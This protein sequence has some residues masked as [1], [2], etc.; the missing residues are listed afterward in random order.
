M[1]ANGKRSA[2]IKIAKVK[3]TKALGKIV[4]GRAEAGFNLEA[5]PA[6]AS[7]GRK[8]SGTK[9]SAATEGS[10]NRAYWGGM[11]GYGRDSMDVNVN[12]SITNAFREKASLSGSGFS[13]KGLFDY[14]VFP[15]AWFRFTTG[16]E[17]FKVSGPAKC[18]SGN[19]Q[20]CDTNINYL[21]LDFMAR[22]VFGSGMIRPWG[23]LFVG[24]LFR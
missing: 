21:T 2:L 12:D 15:Q 7:S 20:T 19:S 3:G 8:R 16:L 4:K 13:A 17:M 14:E 24:L 6:T 18:G 1:Q 9:S 10:P 11:V 22:Y 23:G 5:E